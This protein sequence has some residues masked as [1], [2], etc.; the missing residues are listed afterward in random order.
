MFFEKLPL[1]KKCNLLASGS[2]DEF[3]TQPQSNRKINRHTNS[4]VT[5]VV[6][7]NSSRTVCINL[8]L[9]EV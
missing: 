5:Q 3:Q 8:V 6:K 7:N 2:D 4:S 9:L 1:F